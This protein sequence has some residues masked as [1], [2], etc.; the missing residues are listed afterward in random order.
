[1]TAS[2]PPRS[3]GTPSASKN[4]SG[5]SS[6]QWKKRSRAPIRRMPSSHCRS[7]DSGR[8]DAR[9]R[10][11]ALIG[12]Q[13]GVASIPA[14]DQNH[15][16]HQAFASA[17]QRVQ[18]AF[19][20]LHR[21]ERSFLASDDLDGVVS[22]GGE[23]SSR[24]H[25]ACERLSEIL[26]R[27]QRHLDGSSTSGANAGWLTHDIERPRADKAV[28]DSKVMIQEGQ[29][30]IRGQRRE[31]ER[32]AGELYRRGV[33]IH[34][35]EAS[36][37]DRA[38]EAGPRR[39]VDLIGS[40]GPLRQQ[41]PL[42][43]VCKIA[44]GRNQE[45]A[46]PHG[47]IHDLEVQ[48]RVRGQILDDRRKGPADEVFRQRSWRV[49]G[50]GGLPP[51]R[52]REHDRAIGNRG[53]E[54][55][56]ALVHGAELFDAE[57]GIRDPLTPIARSSRGDGEQDVADPTI[58]DRDRFGKRR[59]RGSEQ[60]AVERRDPERPRTTTA[61]CEARDGQDRLPHARRPPVALDP[62]PQRFDRVTV[63]VDRMPLRDEPA[64][65]GE[66]QEQDPKDYG[67]SVGER[68]V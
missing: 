59:R 2:N 47:G 26:L 43:R 46:A 19:R 60:P 52:S 29:R 1:M 30:P 61:M 44:A 50:P 39:S 37:R 54:V 32:Q 63:P 8:P 66:Q 36:L 9:P 14:N 4:T 68:F 11:A 10:A 25:H 28:A 27:E 6:S 45:R 3:S 41:R 40:D 20:Q 64:R 48:Q 51:S 17:R 58:V 38:A 24:T 5:N 65:F 42:V 49:E 18:W 62:R 34:A 22:L 23:S 13:A 21:C 33:S 12:P 57:V 16:A 67:E 53:S 7:T 56:H 35:I 31:P 15:T 55:E